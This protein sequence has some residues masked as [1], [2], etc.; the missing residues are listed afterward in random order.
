M[1]QADPQGKINHSVE[2]IIW[3]RLHIRQQEFMY[4]LT[5][6]EQVMR[7]AQ[8]MRWIKGVYIVIRM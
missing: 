8:I 1:N 6:K 5:P 3:Y 2:V 4:S 7:Y